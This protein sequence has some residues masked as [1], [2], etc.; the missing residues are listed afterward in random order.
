MIGSVVAAIAAL[1]V[2][3]ADEGVVYFRTPSELTGAQELTSGA[4]PETV[5]LAGLVV[6]GSVERSTDESWLQLTDGAVEVDVRFA[7]RLPATVVEGEGAVVE[8][9]LVEAEVFYADRVLLRHSNEYRPA[10]S[11]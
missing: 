4:Q 5:R 8:G 7:G 3:F 6:P 10:E 1:G 2:K 9:R 11:R